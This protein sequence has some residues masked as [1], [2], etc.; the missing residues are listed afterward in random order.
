MAVIGVGIDLVEI[1]R[2]D[3]MLSRR[4]EQALDRLLTPR[5]RAYVE[6]RG[7]P[8]RHFAARLAAKEAVY[9]ALQSLP[10]ARAI[11]WR[12]I[13]VISGEEGRPH[14]ELHGLALELATAAGGVQLHVS[15]THTEQT[16]GAVA[17]VETV[18][19]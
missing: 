15:L 10:G 4:E 6:A 11:G 9:K 1:E 2:A 5:E 19:G 7:Y 13:E 18:G 17:I 12:E 3:R 14:L 8:A 16:A